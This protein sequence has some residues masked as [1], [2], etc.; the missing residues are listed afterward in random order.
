[1]QVFAASRASSQIGCKMV[2]ATLVASYLRRQLYYEVRCPIDATQRDTKDPMEAI[3]RHSFIPV[4]VRYIAPMAT[5]GGHVLSI[6]RAVP[7]AATSGGEG[8]GVLKN[9]IS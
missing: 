3:I 8:G 4:I 5:A 7:K 1:M 6:A 2:Q 9:W